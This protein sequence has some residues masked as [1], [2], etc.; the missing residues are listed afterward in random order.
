MATI[1]KQG[2][3]AE[4]GK[5]ADKYGS[6]QAYLDCFDKNS[7]LKAL[8]DGIGHFAGQWVRNF[9]SIATDPYHDDDITIEQGTHQV[10][11]TT[12]GGFC[13]HFT[14]RDNYG[15]AFHFYVVQDNGGAL[16]ITKITYYDGNLKTFLRS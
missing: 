4:K 1:F 14:G 5:Y 8:H 13:L 11:D 16:I 3:D 6:Y 7:I 15:Y 9:L 10:E 2:W 12:G